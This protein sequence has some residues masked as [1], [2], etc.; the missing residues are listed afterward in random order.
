MDLVPGRDE[1]SLEIRT[2]L[3]GLTAGKVSAA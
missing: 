1:K 3:W 2:S